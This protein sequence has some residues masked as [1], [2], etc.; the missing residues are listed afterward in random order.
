MTKEHPMTT[1]WPGEWV[2]ERLGA[3]LRTTQALPGLEPSALMGPAVFL[4][5]LAVVVALVAVSCLLLA[6]AAWVRARAAV[7][8]AAQGDGLVPV[9]TGEVVA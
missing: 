9:V 7:R 3:D 4:L 8:S 2:A 6:G 5:A 1:T